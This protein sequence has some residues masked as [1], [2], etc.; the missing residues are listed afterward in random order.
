MLT[1]SQFAHI[2]TKGDWLS[3][4]DIADAYYHTPIL[5]QFQHYFAF[6]YNNKTYCFTVLPFGLAT[7]PFL[8]TSLLRPVIAYFRK[9]GIRIHAYLD[10]F[11]ILSSNYKKAKT[12]THFVVS[13]LQMLGFKI[14]FKKSELNPTQNILFLGLQWNSHP[15]QVALPLEK[16]QKLQTLILTFLNSQE[17]TCR[18]LAQILGLI[19][20][21][22]ITCSALRRHVRQLQLTLIDE[23]RLLPQNASYD[24]PIQISPKVFATLNWWLQLP[25]HSFSCSLVPPIF[26]RS[27]ATDASDWGWGAITDDDSVSFPWS[28][29]LLTKSIAYRELLAV[30]L[31]LKHFKSLKNQTISLSIDN[32][33]AAAYIRKGGGTK[34]RTLL[35]LACD[36]L[37]FTENINSSIQPIYISSNWNYQADVLSHNLPLQEWKLADWAFSII[38]KRWGTPQLDLFA[39]SRTTKTKLYYTLDKNDNKALGHNAMIHSWPHQYSL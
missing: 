32:T 28:T 36:I 17:Q 7:G 26:S 10:D 8:F 29:E 2:I 5:H 35:K 21:I 14:N 18:S 6:Y 1:M 22:L 39:S 37:Q 16:W 38:Y 34:S 4:C 3:K 23:R 19:N 11:I 25:L 33:T 31:A 27:L 15:P 20:F 24:L 30:F 13:E 12:D 9:E